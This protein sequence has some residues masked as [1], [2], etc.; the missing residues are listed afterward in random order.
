M[1]TLTLQER[2]LY[3]PSLSSWADIE[4]AYVDKGLIERDSSPQIN[5]FH[6]DTLSQA[7]GCGYPII[8][9]E[10]PFIKEKNTS[11]PCQESLEEIRK[12]TYEAL[13]TPMNVSLSII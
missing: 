3:D 12:R 10:K 1:S 2:A 13:L 9:A 6:Q 4:Q 8:N 5:P 7:R 11:F